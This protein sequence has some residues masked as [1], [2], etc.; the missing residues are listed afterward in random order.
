MCVG[1]GNLKHE[2]DWKRL[3]ESHIN[4]TCE[5]FLHILPF[6]GL[7]SIKKS[8]EVHLNDGTLESARQLHE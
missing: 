3:C 5:I 7:S 4:I 2:D 6:K 8:G 1:A